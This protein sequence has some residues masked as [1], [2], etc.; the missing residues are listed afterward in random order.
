MTARSF[1]GGRY[2]LEASW[3]SLDLRFDVRLETIEGVLALAQEWAGGR[4]LTRDD[5]SGLRLLLEELLL[6]I[7][8]HAAT[9]KTN[10]ESELFV[11]LR[12]DLA[13]PA[14]ERGDRG[15][16]A[17]AP[18][19]RPDRLLITLR[20]PGEPFD[21]RTYAAE[22][23]ASIETAVPGGRGLSL[24]RLFSV[25]RAYRREDG[26]NVLSLEMLLGGAAGRADSGGAKGGARP[27][28]MPA[29]PGFPQKALR[30]WRE[31]LALR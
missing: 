22:Q 18:P 19:L 31:K 28:D 29:A 15:T 23:P 10:G 6:N 21:P 12:L 24:V 3:R 27:D 16:E 7:R 9:G 11:S 1:S 30:V 17:T 2:G 8:Q 13:F 25:N 26:N 4:G 5:R 20:D 14:E